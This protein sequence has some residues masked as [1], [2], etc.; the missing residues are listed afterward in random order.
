MKWRYKMKESIYTLK[1]HNEGI[2]Y[3][4]EN[5]VLEEIY[6]LLEHINGRMSDIEYQIDALI[7]IENS[8]NI[9]PFNILEDDINF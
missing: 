2:T 8:Q 6:E 5:E 1:I 3:L 4:E 9:K 7:T